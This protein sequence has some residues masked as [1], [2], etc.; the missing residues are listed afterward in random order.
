MIFERQKCHH[1][2]NTEHEVMPLLALTLLIRFFDILLFNWI[3]SVFSFKRNIVVETS[4]TF[5][6]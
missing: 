1:S 6:L 4:G 5:Y 2:P 3:P